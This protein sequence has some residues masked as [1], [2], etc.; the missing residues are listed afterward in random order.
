MQRVEL[1]R[2]IEGPSERAGL[3]VE[4]ALVERLAD[5]VAGEIGGLPLLSTALVDLYRER[6][7]RLLTLASYERSGGVSGAIGRHAETTF[8]S[9]DGESQHVAKSIFLRLISGGGEEPFAR[10][11]AR[12]TE[13]DA[14]DA[15]VAAVLATLVEC[16]LLVADD[17]TVELVHEALIEQWPRLSAWLE[18]DVEGRRLHRHLT[19]S[20]A[21]WAASRRDAGELYRG[22][23]LAATL[24]W[25]AGADAP[26]LNRVEAEFVD[27]SRAAATVEAERQRR[28]NRRLRGILA[29]AVALLVVAV[30]TGAV[31]LVERGTARSRET[32]AIAQ[33]LGAQALAEPR[34]DRALLLAREGVNLDDSL[35]TRTNLLAALLRSPA[36]LAVLPGGGSRVLD[37]AVSADGRV[38]VARGDN[39]SVTFFD[40]NTLADVGRRF[41]GN[42][43][44]S[45]CGAIV[46]PLRGLAVSPDGRSLAVGDGD[47]R[48]S[49]LFVLD[50]RS[51]RA[52][53]IVRDRNAAIP[54]ALFA[55]DGHMLFTG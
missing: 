45:Y 28:A 3:R 8:A 55:R 13:L 27:A 44:I 12:R 6:D 43:R 48:A 39:G 54:D 18:E 51:H 29:A 15:Q 24:E 38:L 23:R 46:R 7:G 25:V 52:K 2:A 36:A 5:E 26:A 49:E 30:A 40:A 37:D 53:A 16:R 19:Q 20:A 14:D 31:A 41:A 32:A 50:L 4:P 33:R 35:A 17:G 21:A 1:R 47:G 22:A 34:L 11:R 42:G 10:R 9:L